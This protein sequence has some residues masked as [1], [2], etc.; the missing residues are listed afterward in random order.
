MRCVCSKWFD[1]R[2]QALKQ[3]DP[4]ARKRAR[5]ERKAKG[6]L[7]KPGPKP[8]A[9]RKLEIAA[10]DYISARP[11]VQV[12]TLLPQLHPQF[13]ARLSPRL[14]G[15]QV[16]KD[17][18]AAAGYTLEPAPDGFAADDYVQSQGETDRGSGAHLNP[19]ASS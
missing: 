9:Q 19:W 10:G 7:L 3:S 4:I 15:S 14:R 6:K 17:E 2:R 1:N 12:Q 8:K 13:F 18:L 16:G 11:S 5:E